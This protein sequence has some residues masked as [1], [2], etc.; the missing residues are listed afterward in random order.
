MTTV[1][2]TWRVF[3]P[4]RVDL[5]QQADEFLARLEQHLTNVRA[6]L[7]QSFSKK[8]GKQ[9]AED[10][11]IVVAWAQGDPTD[12]VTLAHLYAAGRNEMQRHENLWRA[13]GLPRSREEQ[14]QYRQA[15]CLFSKRWGPAL[16]A[17]ESAVAHRDV[18]LAEL[19]NFGELQRDALVR[20]LQE[21]RAVRVTA[22]DRPVVVAIVYADRKQVCDVNV[23][24]LLRRGKKVISLKRQVMYQGFGLPRRGSLPTQT[25]QPPDTPLDWPSDASADDQP[26]SPVARGRDFALFIPNGPRMKDHLPLSAYDMDSIA[27]INPGVGALPLLWLKRLTC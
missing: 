23:T 4:F 7:Q 10:D 19:Q 3:C 16:T 14:R 25:A 17:Y 11:P 18:A 5:E 26:A 1:P 27:K 8:V 6:E 22:S 20:R 13:T 2:E 12:W 24:D 15:V 21:P 9:L